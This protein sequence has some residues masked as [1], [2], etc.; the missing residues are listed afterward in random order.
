MAF[1]TNWG[2]DGETWGVIGRK[3]LSD[4][5]VSGAQLVNIC[6]IHGLSVTNTMCEHRDVHKCSWYWDTLGLILMINF[7]VV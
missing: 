7:V 3:G 5:K 6:A 4:L 1:N 2:Y